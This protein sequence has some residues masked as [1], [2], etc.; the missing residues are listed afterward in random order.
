M[1]LKNFIF[2]IIAS[3]LSGCAS[4]G[5]FL[6]V[7]TNASAAKIDTYQTQTH[8]RSIHNFNAFDLNKKIHQKKLEKKVDNLFV[9]LD[10]SDGMNEVYREMKL[11]DYAIEILNRFNLSFPDIKIKGGM[12][13][14]GDAYKSETWNI[15]SSKRTDPFNNLNSPILINNQLNESLFQ[16]SIQENKLSSAINVLSEKMI[17]ADGRSALMIISRW[18]HVDAEAI[19]AVDYLRQKIN[20]TSLSNHSG[21]SICVYTVGM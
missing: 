14:F 7:P 9:L 10:M 18:E 11:N 16:H 20:T 13:V 4:Q 6:D 12:T 21:K 15:F 5:L 17:E 1:L 19:E 2:I 8:Q 3:L